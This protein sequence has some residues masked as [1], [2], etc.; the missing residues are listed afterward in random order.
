[1]ENSTKTWLRWIAVLPGALAA[2][3]LATIPLHFLL[4]LA[5]ARNGTLLGFIELPPGANIPIERAL[6]PLVIAITFILVGFEIAP[7]YKFKTAAV[8]AALYLIFA[9]GAIIFA[10][11][12]GLQ[13]SFGAR[14]LG[15]IAGILTG[16]YLA[17]RKSNLSI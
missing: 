12:Y 3:L 1:M 17:W 9:I 5:F 2:G 16:L 11:N 8:L 14:T 10:T 13:L 7:R 15:P 6:Y 4:Y